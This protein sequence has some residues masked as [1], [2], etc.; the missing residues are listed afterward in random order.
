MKGRRTNGPFVLGFCAILAGLV[1]L[2]GCRTSDRATEHLW[3]P[4]GRSA[5]VV[6]ATNTDT[7]RRTSPQAGSKPRLVLS[8]QVLQSPFHDYDQA[9]VDAIETKWNDILDHGSFPHNVGL[10]VLQFTLKWNGNVSDI[11]VVRTTVDEKATRVCVW[12]I[13]DSAP[14]P[15]WPVSTRK[16]VGDSRVIKF[17]F[18]YLK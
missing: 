5:D 16:I 13:S 12:A 3:S 9:F 14:F 8:T 15:P 17:T 18:N 4:T 7:S 6:V 10:V 1:L 11:Q 2:A